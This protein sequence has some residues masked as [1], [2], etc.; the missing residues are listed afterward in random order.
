MNTN[1]IF[2]IMIVLIFGVSLFGMP[3]SLV[4]AQTPSVIT[5]NNDHDN[6]LGSLRQAITDAN[7]GDVIIFDSPY[8]TIH[9]ASSLVIDKELTIYGGVTLSGDTEGD[10]VGDIRIMEVKS[11]AL[12]N[13]YAMHITLG[14][15]E[16]GGGFANYGI[17]NLRDF[18]LDYNHA[19]NAGGAIYNENILILSTMGFGNNSA[20]NGGAVYNA[21][22]GK[23]WVGDNYFNSNSSVNEGGA[24]YNSGYLE[25]NRVSFEFNNSGN[26]AAIRNNGQLVMYNNV[27][28]SNNAVQRGGALYDSG[29]STI[30]H[31]T[32][33]DN[34]APIGAGIFKGEV[35]TTILRNTIV[36]KVLESSV[37]DNCSGGNIDGGNYNIS[38]PDATCPGM[39]ADPKL[40]PE[41]VWGAW[42]VPW[43][44]APGS[45]A[46]NTADDTVCTTIPN[47]GPLDKRGVSRPQGSHCDIGAYEY[48]NPNQ[49]PVITNIIAPATPIQPR[50]SINATVE[51][52]DPDVGD[53]HTVLWD[54]GDGS[55]I[56]APA[57][58][59]SVTNSHT[60]TTA[61][62]YTIVATITDAAG[63]TAQATTQVTVIPYLTTLDPAKVWIGLKNSDDIGTKFDLLAEVYQN[64]TLIG[65]GQLDKVNGG[66]SGFNNAK[67]NTIPLTLFGPIDWPSS[68][69]LK[70]KLY[71]RNTCYGNTHNS[72]TAR[73][74][75]NDASANSQFGAT[76]ED[77]TQN[78]FL[79][80]GFN[81]NIVA[82]TGPRKTIDV[83]A[84]R[85]CSPFKLFGTWTIV[86]P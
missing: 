52:S 1:K 56:T 30:I 50:Q 33:S 51:F 2:K 13:L 18:Y 4:F 76:I 19:T 65:S 57:T 28:S 86:V 47:P 72:G 67:L 21:G 10:G 37:G 3:N 81:L 58:A 38:W 41:D 80:D 45:A 61:G 54:W 69:T 32:F 14:S 20:Y 12:A 5:V 78:Y 26:G 25:V 48:V 27:I 44:L 63:A 66:S 40:I 11:G 74:W 31:S 55:A 34:F 6:G 16:N 84:G 23:V 82:G 53:T 17:L 70:I 24:F 71:V 43:A 73:L 77:T 35:G 22:T 83:A 62:V 36:A 68:S 85:P 9:L 64:S 60:Y 75:Y 39:N 42:A 29:T 7:P 79:I 8:Y 15:S 59:P 46:I 49:P